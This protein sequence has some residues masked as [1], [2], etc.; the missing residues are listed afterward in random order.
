[1]RE[2][3]SSDDEAVYL[4][5]GGVREREVVGHRDILRPRQDSNLRHPV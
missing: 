3:M 2:L 1:M 4:N 5:S